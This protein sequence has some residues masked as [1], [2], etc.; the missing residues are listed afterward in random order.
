MLL[1]EAIARRIA[2]QWEVLVAEGERPD[3]GWKSNSS[4]K[5][6]RFCSK[7]GI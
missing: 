6:W 3:E 7:A 1:S 4:G 2:V 5:C